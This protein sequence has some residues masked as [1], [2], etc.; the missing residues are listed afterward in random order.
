MPTYRIEGKFY[1]E[2]TF[3]VF[4][5]YLATAKIKTVKSLTAQLVPH[6]TGLFGKIR[7][8]KISSG[9]PG[10][11]FAKVCTRRNFPL[12]IIYCDLCTPSSSE[13]SFAAE[14]TF[15]R[16]LHSTLVVKA[17]KGLLSNGKS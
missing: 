3:V 12:Y 13:S 1:M 16:Q 9:S 2:Q 6:H 17:K 7:T 10:G 4:V 15:L 5:D 14:A 8:V 11:I